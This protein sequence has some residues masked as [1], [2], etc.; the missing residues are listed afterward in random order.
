MCCASCKHSY[1]KHYWTEEGRAELLRTLVKEQVFGGD[2][3]QQ[4]IL[5]ADVINR[6]H[7]VAPKYGGRW[8]DVGVGNGACVFTCSEFGHTTTGIDL[9]QTYIDALVHYGYDAVLADA[10]EYDYT[11]ADVVFLADILEHLPYPDQLL[12]RIRNQSW[13]TVFVSCPNMD[14]VSWRY[15]DSRGKNVYWGEIEHH[16][17]FTR[18]SMEALLKR[19]KFT[20][21]N[22]SISRRYGACMEIIAI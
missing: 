1:T 9:R 12:T 13:A 22:Y 2:L 11:G 16:H 15:M 10:M 20:P 14:T 3:D 19:C 8:I 5:W 17:N 21:V 7:A 4:R 18:A 6:V